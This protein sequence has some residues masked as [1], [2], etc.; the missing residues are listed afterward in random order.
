LDVTCAGIYCLTFKVHSA[1]AAAEYLR[2]KGL[3]LVRY[4]VD[5]PNG[6]DGELDFAALAGFIPAFATRLPN[7]TCATAAKSGCDAALRAVLAF[8]SVA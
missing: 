6:L 5:K 1:L 4:C 7:A 3:E 8:C 2:G